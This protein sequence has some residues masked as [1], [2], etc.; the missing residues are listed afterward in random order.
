MQRPD[1]AILLVAV[2]VAARIKPLL[3]RF[4]RSVLPTLLII[5]TKLLP[6]DPLT[7]PVVIAAKVNTTTAAEA[8]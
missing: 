6:Y 1:I 7:D 2:D 5:P 8:L 3:E 4:M